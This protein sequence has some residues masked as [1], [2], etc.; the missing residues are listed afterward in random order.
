[1]Q[2]IES[3][4]EL[5]IQQLNRLQ[6]TNRLFLCADDE[7]CKEILVDQDDAWVDVHDELFWFDH[8]N[9]IYLA[10]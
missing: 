4:G 1:M 2:F 6:N 9:A 7:S 5:L 10:E 8:D 3:T